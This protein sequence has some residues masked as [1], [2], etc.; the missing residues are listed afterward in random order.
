MSDDYLW[1]RRDPH[2]PEVARL[3]SVLRHL[4]M[5][6][7]HILVLPAQAPPRRL[8]FLIAA[9][10]TAA[11]VALLGGL[12]WTHRSGGVA[13]PI[14]SVAGTPRVSSVAVSES[15]TLGVG[16]WLETDAQARASID[17]GGIG[18]VEVDPDTRIGLVGSRDGNYRL[19]LDRGTMHALIWAPPGRFF[20][21]T[22]SSTAV[23]LG[24]AYTLTVNDDGTGLVRVTSGWVG[25][26]WRGRESFIP[27]GAVCPTRRQL[28]PGT[29]RYDDTSS[30]FQAALDAIDFGGAPATRS[31]AVALVL[32]EARERDVV[33]LWHLLTRVAP[34]DRGRVFDRLAAF[35][36]PPAGVTRQGIAAGRREML[37]EWWDALGLG[38][39]S[40]WRTWKQPWRTDKERGTQ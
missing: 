5:P 2:D 20:V 26:E 35:V 34:A 6:E 8:P 36:P 28:G 9:L 17:V 1:D 27:A 14:T 40:W 37:D 30:A 29:P 7:P 22:P 25:F 13:L 32:A 31:S 33:T 18:R 4:R 10:A 39:A 23:D 3:E 38:T 19:R 24:C 11:S 16:R 12:V 21:D 15:T